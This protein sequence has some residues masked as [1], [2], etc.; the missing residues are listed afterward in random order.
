MEQAKHTGRAKLTI[1][2]V[3]LALT[4]LSNVSGRELARRWGVSHATVNNVRKGQ[5]WKAHVSLLGLPIKEKNNDT[6]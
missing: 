6:K 3:V 5:S 4:E 2:Q 1:D